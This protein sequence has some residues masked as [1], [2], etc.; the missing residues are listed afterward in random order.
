MTDAPNKD[1][2]SVS[3]APRGTEPAKPE[4]AKP[5]L[6]GF[7]GGSPGSVILKLIFASLIVGALMALLGLSPR[8]VV[9]GMLRLVRSIWDMGFDALHEVSGWL[10]AGAM[11]VVPLWFVMRLINGRKS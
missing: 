8:A 10:I 1:A 6:A 2:P 5:A 4:P 11:I 9:D 7:L 3:Q